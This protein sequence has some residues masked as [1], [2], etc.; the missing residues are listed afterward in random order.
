M[1]CGI[2]RPG[3]IYCQTDQGLGRSIRRKDWGIP[4]TDRVAQLRPFSTG[5]IRAQRLR[6]STAPS[7][8][9]PA[10]VTSTAT[11]SSRTT[12]RHRRRRF[13]CP[14]PACCSRPVSSGCCGGAGL[15]PRPDESRP[16]ALR[17]DPAPA[18]TAPAFRASFPDSRSSATRR[19]P[20]RSPGPRRRDRGRRPRLWHSGADADTSSPSPPI[21]Q[22]GGGT[23]I[24]TARRAARGRPGSGNPPHEKSRGAAQHR[25]H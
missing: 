3:M 9:R 19:N 15:S 10:P 6:S 5:I 13:H 24:D 11:T 8:P 18:R 1:R 22:S 7:S 20:P 16:R 25:G 23:V 4:R 12:F 17:A 21:W 14:P 2:R